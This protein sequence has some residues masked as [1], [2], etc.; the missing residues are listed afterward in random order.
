MVERAVCVWF[1]QQL[2]EFYAA[3]CQGLLKRW[4]KCLNL[5]RDYAEQ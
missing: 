3:G 4:D 2:Q 1:P 5:Y